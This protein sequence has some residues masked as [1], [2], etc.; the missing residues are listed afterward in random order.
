[1]AK[2]TSYST[3]VTA[4][5][6][7]AENDGAEFLA[8]IPTAIDLAE[9]MMFKELDLPEFTTKVTGSLT[10]SNNKIS[11]PTGYHHMRFF[12]ITQANDAKKFLKKRNEDFLLDY[13]PNENVTGTP[14]YYSDSSDTEFILA[15]TPDSG[16]SYEMKYVKKPDSLTSS[17]T[18]NYYTTYCP[19]IIFYATMLQMSIFMKSEM[20]LDKWAKAYIASR[21][22]WNN[23][24]RRTRR[25]DGEVPNATNPS[26]NTVIHTSNTNS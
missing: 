9:Q 7:A 16:Y 25:D 14:K 1:M 10:S 5:Q 13:W 2:I 15:P 4:I 8:Y 3:L 11:K 22:S 12:N 6:D 20:G 26:P 21:D 19:D 18:T 17:N 23:S 24:N